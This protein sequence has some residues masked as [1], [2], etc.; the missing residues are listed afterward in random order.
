[1]RGNE[2]DRDMNFRLDQLLLEIKPT[3]STQP[4]VEDEATRYIRTLGLQKFLRGIKVLYLQ[5]DRL[6]EAL[7]GAT[8]RWIVIHQKNNRDR[9]GHETP[10]AIRPGNVI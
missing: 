1:L 9:I 4:D 10:F 3:Y 5:S 2:D 6:D 8:H 7:D